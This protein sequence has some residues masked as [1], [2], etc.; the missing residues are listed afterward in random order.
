MDSKVERRTPWQA[1]FVAYCNGVPEDEIALV[2]NTPLMTLKKRMSSESW[3]SLREKL[4]LATNGAGN[5][6]ST[7]LEPAT[8]AKLKVLEENRQENL[9][10]FTSL[11]DDLLDVLA[12]LRSGDLKLEKQFHNRGSVV[13]AVVDPSIVDRVNLATYAQTVANGTYRAL[14]DFQGQEK[15]GQDASAGTAAPTGPAITIILPGAIGA[16][17]EQREMKTAK[18]SEVI[19]LTTLTS[20][21]PAN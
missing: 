10:V 18:G 4:P 7:A 5:G 15:A 21:N 16:P 17:R 20:E 11:R 1:M 13:R 19:D 12:K 14:G 6:R 2:F 9:K 8:N 3:A